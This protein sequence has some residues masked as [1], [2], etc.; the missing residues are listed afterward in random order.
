LHEALPSDAIVVGDPVTS[1]ADLLALLLPDSRRTYYTS[2]GG[3]LGWGFSAA[4]GVALA[5]PGQRVVSIVGDGVFQFGVHTL[6]TAAALG[7]PLTVVVIDNSS[8]AAVRAAMK[9][10]R[11]S[12]SGPF[13]ASDLSGFDVVTAA[14]GF[15]AWATSVE[16]LADLGAA[17][18][19]AS[20]QHG[21][22]VINVR[23]DPS[24]TG[25]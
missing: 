3:S 10:Y 17:L 12:Q 20:A 22:A 5:S 21:P 1:G 14:R 16:R 9:R 23:T 19:A 25:P 13:P 4:L 2:S 11:G 15:G 18:D 24:N 8:Y 6:W 7:V